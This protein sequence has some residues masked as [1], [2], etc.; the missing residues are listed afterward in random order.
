M[1]KHILAA[2][3]LACAAAGAFAVDINKA[4]RPNSKR[5]RASDRTAAKHPRR[6][7]EVAVQ[8]LADVMQRVER[9]QG[10]HARQA[11]GAA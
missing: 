7:Q 2:A 10:G 9:H 11:V 8:G 3:R 5:S 6:T 4:T 1:F